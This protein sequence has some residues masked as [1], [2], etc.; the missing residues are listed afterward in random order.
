MKIPLYILDENKNV[1]KC[2][3]EDFE[4]WVSIPGNKIIKQEYCRNFKISTVFLG[5]DHS[6]NSNISLWFE[7]MIFNENDQDVYCERYTTYDQAVEG[8]EYSK[9]AFF[10]DITSMIKNCKCKLRII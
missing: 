6:Y 1:V 10:E 2:S 9:R 5:M 4:K 7:T 8:H 3:V